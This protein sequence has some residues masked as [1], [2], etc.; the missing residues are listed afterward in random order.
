MDMCTA[1]VSHIPECQVGD[2]VV[3][4]G[5][6]GREKL[7]AHDLAAR[8]RTISYEILCALGKR[9]PRVFISRGKKEDVEPRPRRIYIPGEEK[10]LSRIDAIIRQCFQ[11]RTRNKELGGAIFSEIFETLF[12]KDD[13][14][15]EL[16]TNF[17]YAIHIA[18]FSEAEISADRQLENFFKVTTH[19]EYC[20]AIREETLFI[21]RAHDNDQLAALFRDPLCEY[22]WLLGPEDRHN[23]EKDFRLTR[24]A[25]DG[26]TVPPLRA[27]RT[28]RGYE[29]WCGGNVLKEKIDQDAKI[30]FELVSKKPKWSNTF[31]VY[32]AYPTRGLNI[33]FDYSQT[34]IKNVR[35][36][37]F[38]AGRT[39]YPKRT[40]EKGKF[41]AL[42]I[43]NQEWI[44]PNS[45]VTFIWNLEKNSGEE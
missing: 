11:A 30:E 24:F 25:V 37:A 43:D 32:L 14:Q 35:D 2:E 29:V 27:V 3:L 10:S 19:I 33:S 15:L 9:A 22:R 23:P 45:G 5:Q 34:G 18:D 26:Q 44:F 40:R 42:Q 28:E 8:S 17:R 13:R 36:I 38:F 4:L 41:I 39:P 6:S 16:R 20:K 7:D 1:D 31:S 12:G 21:A